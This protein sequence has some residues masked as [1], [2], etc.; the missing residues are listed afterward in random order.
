MAS[1]NKNR[2]CYNVDSSNLGMY[3]M[4][5]YRK[6]NWE[7]GDGTVCLKNLHEIIKSCTND[8]SLQTKVN[9][10]CVFVHKLTLSFINSS[11]YIKG[12]FGKIRKE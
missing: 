8:F 7:K 9:N 4:T 6:A 2:T 12:D 10:F 11:Q 5:T 3:P 1:Q